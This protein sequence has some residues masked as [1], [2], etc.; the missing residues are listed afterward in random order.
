MEVLYIYIMG[1][2]SSAVSLPRDWTTRIGFPSGART[3]LHHYQTHSASS[4]MGIG[5][6]SRG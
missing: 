5:C 2:G 1:R 4:G 3:S 6:S